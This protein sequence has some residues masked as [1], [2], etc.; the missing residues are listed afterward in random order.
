M[1]PGRHRL[2]PC[3]HSGVPLRPEPLFSYDIVLWD[4]GLPSDLIFLNHLFKDNLP[5]GAHS[6]VPGVRVGV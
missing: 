3:P 1:T 2:P 6:E 5:K 4:R